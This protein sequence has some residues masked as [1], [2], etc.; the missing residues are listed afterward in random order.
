MEKLPQVIFNK[1]QFAELLGKG[2]TTIDTYIQNGTVHPLPSFD[3]PHFSVQELERLMSVDGKIKS[4]REIQLE[5][6][7]ESLTKERDL[8]K[9]RLQR[10]QEALR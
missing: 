9:D 2:T 6:T 3:T 10:I 5:R 4:L 7:V 8:L 1:T